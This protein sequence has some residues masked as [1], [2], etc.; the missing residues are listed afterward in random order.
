M[1]SLLAPERP[2]PLADRLDRLGVGTATAPV[3]PGGSSARDPV[4]PVGAEL[5][6]LLPGG[7]L[8]RG[9]VLQVEGSVALT[10]ALLA[11]SSASGVWCALVGM[12]TVGLL[13][14]AEL[15]IDTERLALVPQPGA[16]WP[17]VVAALVDALDIVVVRPPSELAPARTR[18]LAARARERGAVLVVQGRWQ[19]AEIRLR[20]LHTRWHG[21]GS[22]HGRLAGYE[23]EVES[24]GRGAAS[25]PRR[26]QLRLGDDGPARAA[27]VP[28]RSQA[29]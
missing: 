13:A 9:S 17:V 3:R 6:G 8:R 5:A 20:P 22:G 16:D 27:P 7:G 28:S 25:E 29:A 15:G 18:R 10:L 23:L 2:D 26:A 19:G 1:V 14:A 11:A 21:L 4:L 24:R 12:P